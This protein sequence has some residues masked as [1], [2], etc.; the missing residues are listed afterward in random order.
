MYIGFTRR[1]HVTSAPSLFYLIHILAGQRPLRLGGHTSSVYLPLHRP[2]SNRLF[3][4]VTQYLLSTQKKKSKNWPRIDIVCWG[5][6]GVWW[7]NQIAARQKHPPGGKKK[8]DND[9]AVDFSGWRASVR[10][11]IGFI[12]KIGGRYGSVSSHRAIGG[13]SA[14]WTS[15]S[16][17]SGGGR[18]LAGWPGY[19]T[20]SPLMFS[21][22][23]P[24]L[25][26]IPAAI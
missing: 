14:R 13:V 8:R 20:H 16:I 1:G 4:H 2:Q 11:C 23:P 10:Q 6:Y 21:S 19:I 12:I 7:I 17:I 9:P 24:S 3:E 15:P 26:N 18:V 22:P 5:L 25:Y